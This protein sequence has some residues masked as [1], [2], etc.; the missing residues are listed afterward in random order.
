MQNTYTTLKTAQEDL[1]YMN[2]LSK[3]EFKEL[4]FAGSTDDYVDAKWDSFTR[5]MIFFIWECS[6]DKIQLMADF[7]DECKGESQ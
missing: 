1:K 2:R 5:N 6:Y 3:D 7:I 4:L